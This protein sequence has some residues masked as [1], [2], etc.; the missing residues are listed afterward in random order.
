MGSKPWAP[1]MLVAL[2]SGACHRGLFIRGPYRF[3]RHPMCLGVN[4]LPDGKRWGLNFNLQQKG[5]FLMLA[6]REVA[7][8]QRKKRL[9]D[10]YEKKRSRNCLGE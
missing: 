2:L 3:I 1:G 8:I 7:R 9:I 4:R 10:H 5:L 6:I